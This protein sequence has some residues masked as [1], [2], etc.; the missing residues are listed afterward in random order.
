MESPLYAFRYV[1]K[2]RS[3][4]EG[5]AQC[6]GNSKSDETKLEV[7]TKAR[8]PRNLA[9][10]ERYP[11]RIKITWSYDGVGTPNEAAGIWILDIGNQTRPVITD[12]LLNP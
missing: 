3:K 11:S 10:V 8:A 12:A 7:K 5:H 4:C 6:I 9:L 2:L 1:F